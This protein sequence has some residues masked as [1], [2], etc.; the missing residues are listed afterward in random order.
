MKLTVFG[1]ATAVMQYSERAAA[2]GPEDPGANPPPRC[3]GP[4]APRP[5]VSGPN[6]PGRILRPDQVASLLDRGSQVREA[7]GLAVP[8]DLRSAPGP[9]ACKASILERCFTC[10]EGKCVQNDGQCV[11]DVNAN[12]D[13]VRWWRV[14][15]PFVR[16]LLAVTVRELARR[17]LGGG[18]TPLTRGPRISNT[19]SRTP[20]SLRACRAPCVP[21]E[22]AAGRAVVRPGFCLRQSAAGELSWTGRH[23]ASPQTELLGAR[24]LC[25]RFSEGLPSPMEGQEG[26]CVRACVRARVCPRA[27]WGGAGLLE[28]A[29]RGGLL[30]GEGAP[31]RASLPPGE[32]S[33][34][35]CPVQIASLSGTT[36]GEPAGVRVRP[37]WVCL[38]FPLAQ[39]VVCI[40]PGL[41]PLVW[42]RCFNG[43]QSLKGELSEA[44]RSSLASW[45][46]VLVLC[47][48]SPGASS[49]DWPHSVRRKRASHWL[50]WCRT[51]CR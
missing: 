44:P 42:R 28:A 33:G 49:S 25:K 48:V 5:R 29:M 3:T 11:R 43:C 51:M 36:A 9:D 31:Q 15:G 23:R 6:I 20:G 16:V 12:Q 18:E 14:C 24:P 1:L 8:L 26:V 37:L 34:G 47:Q 17:R 50:H 2:S 39:P 38:I 35:C 21:L 40:S 7:A 45:L 22:G 19:L 4:G 30:F 27:R 13:C 10:R 32:P 46:S 41:S